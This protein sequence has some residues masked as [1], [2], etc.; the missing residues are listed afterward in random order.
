[1]DSIESTGSAAFS[2]SSPATSSPSPPPAESVASFDNFRPAG[3]IDPYAPDDAAAYVMNPS[4]MD[5]SIDMFFK[6]ELPFDSEIVRSFQDLNDPSGWQDISMPGSYQF[7][8]Q[9]MS[10]TDYML[11]RL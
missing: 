9:A 10:E 5:N 4:A 2:H 6:P 1:M 8:L 3:G 7:S 11:R